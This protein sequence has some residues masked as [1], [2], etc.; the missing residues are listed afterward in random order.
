[1]SAETGAGAVVAVDRQAAVRLI[2]ASEHA[3]T[4]T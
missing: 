1:V 2:A 4:A 3:T